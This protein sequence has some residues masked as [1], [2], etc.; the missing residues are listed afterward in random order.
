MIVYVNDLIIDNIESIYPSFQDYKKKMVY[1]FILRDSKRNCYE[2]ERYK[3]KKIICD[4]LEFE[5][6]KSIVDLK[7]NNIDIEVK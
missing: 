6:V 3:I 5:L 1:T 2:F 7:K 4:K